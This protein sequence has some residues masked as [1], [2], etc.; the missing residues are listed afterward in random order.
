MVARLRRHSDMCVRMRKMATISGSN[1]KLVR[2]KSYIWG[3]KISYPCHI[4]VLAKRNTI[5]QVVYKTKHYTKMICRHR[6]VISM[7]REIYNNGQVLHTSWDHMGRWCSQKLQSNPI[8]LAAA[9]LQ[10]NHFTE[11]VCCTDS[12]SNTSV[13]I[14]LSN[15]LKAEVASATFWKLKKYTRGETCSYPQQADVSILDS[16]RNHTGKTTFFHQTPQWIS[17]SYCPKLSHCIKP[18]ILLGLQGTTR[19]PFHCSQERF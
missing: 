14:A 1:H 3:Y 19:T 17:W 8:P 2:T 12:T 7:A 15:T 10:Y 9:Q 16:T 13:E 4:F 6:A 5:I 18:C 11:P